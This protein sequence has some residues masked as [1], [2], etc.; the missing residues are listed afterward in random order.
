MRAA[1]ALLLFMIALL[2]FAGPAG[3]IGQQRAQG[4]STLTISDTP[5]DD[6]CRG[7]LTVISYQT[8]DALIA[9][10]AQTDRRVAKARA[11]AALGRAIGAFYALGPTERAASP[12]QALRVSASH[13]LTPA[14]AISAWRQ[15]TNEHALRGH[16]LN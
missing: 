3:A 8:G 2:L 14:L 4:I 15:C 13:D 11:L 5:Q 9:S 10:T 12:V 6:P 16:V 1:E 7:L